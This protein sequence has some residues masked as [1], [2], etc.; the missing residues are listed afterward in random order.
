MLRTVAKA[1]ASIIHDLSYVIFISNDYFVLQLKADEF[2]NLDA[3]LEGVLHGAVVT[4]LRSHVY[5]LLA[6]KF[7]K[8]GDVAQL[9]M[10]MRAAKTLPLLRL[11]VR[12]SN[13]AIKP[14][15]KSYFIFIIPSWVLIT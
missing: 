8:R 12:V 4:P 3:I 14:Y 6:D 13:H 7:A 10:G 1:I 2:L 5:G 9:T 11:G 15:Q